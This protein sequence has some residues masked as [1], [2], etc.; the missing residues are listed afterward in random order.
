MARSP[1]SPAHFDRRQFL[2]TSAAAA[3]L[4]MLP[5]TLGA[6]Q[7]GPVGDA[8]GGQPGERHLRGLAVRQDLRADRQA[9][10]AGLVRQG[11]PDHRAQ[12][13]APGGEAHRHVRGR[14]YRW[15]SRSRPC[16]PSRATS[17]RASPRPSTACPAWTSTSR[18]SRRSRS[19]IAQRDGKTVGPALLLHGVGLHLQR[20]AAGQAGFK[21]KPFTSY[22]ELHR[23][24]PQ[25]QEGRRVASIPSCGW[26]GAGFEQLP[27]DLVQHDPQPRRRDLR[28]AARAPARRRVGR[29]RDAQVVAEHVQ[30]GAGRSELAEPALHPGGEG[31]QRRPA[32]LSRHAPPLL[33]QPRE[34]PGAVAD[35]RQGP[36][37][38][39]SRATARPSAYTMLY[40]LPSARPRTRNGRGSCC[41]TSAAAPRTATTRRPSPGDDAMLGSGYQSVMDS[42]S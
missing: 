10:R 34:R 6:Q 11:Q 1:F 13:R 25:G 8:P 18:T 31:V 41:S 26:P 4:S 32:R 36:G 40:F 27:G 33:R 22:P 42:D 3:G 14:R 38:R 39:A 23:A 35:R 7:A 9:V 20:R 12:R 16:S 21:G 37:P 5:G 19:A 24:V 15:T 29:A 17:T 28:Q 30:G 2:R